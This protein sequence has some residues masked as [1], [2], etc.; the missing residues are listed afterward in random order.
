[1]T[2]A[3]KDADL[4]VEVE[5]VPVVKRCPA[6]VLIAVTNVGVEVEALRLGALVAKLA[7]EPEHA[8]VVAADQ[9]D[10]IALLVF[11]AADVVGA[12]SSPRIR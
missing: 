8:E 3:E 10:V 9:I 12:K 4:A 1:M 5:V 6:P 2:I 7:F 11:D